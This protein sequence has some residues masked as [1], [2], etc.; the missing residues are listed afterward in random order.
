MTI[1]KYGYEPEKKDP[2]VKEA[3]VE[4]RC[5]KCGAE[6]KGNPPTCPNHGSEPF[7]KRERDGQE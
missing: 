4:G 6:L 5:P 3:S 7:E 1:E 2:K